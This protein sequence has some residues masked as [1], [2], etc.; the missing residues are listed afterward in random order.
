LAAEPTTLDGLHESAYSVFSLTQNVLETL[1]VPDQGGSVKPNLALS[2]APQGATS[3]EIKLRSGVK[4][5]DGT[6]MTADDVV[7]SVKYALE[8]GSTVQQVYLSQWKDARLIDSSTLRI[9][10]TVQDPIFPLELQFAAVAPA[11]AITKGKDF[12]S[13]SPTGTGP[14]KVAGWTKGLSLTLTAFD[15]YW[16][17]VQPIRDVFFVWRAESSVRADM[18]RTGEAQLAQ[19]LSPAHLQNV[20]KVASASSLDAYILILNVIGQTH[21]SI[22]TDQRVR[23][24]VNYAVDRNALR[25]KLFGG[26]ATL[27]K[28]NLV[29]PTVLGYND[30]LSD[31]AYDPEKAKGLVQDAGATGKTVTFV[32]SGGRFV[33]DSE[34][35]QLVSAQL[36]AIGLKVE[37]TNPPAAV[38][39]DTYRNGPNGLDRPD[40]LIGRAGNETH[41]LPSRTA[42]GFVRS[43][44][45]GGGGLTLDDPQLDQM[46]AAALVETDLN[47]R[48][49][50]SE[51]MS[52]YLRDRA[53]F[54]SLLTPN[55]TWG[56][57][58]NLNFTITPDGFLYLK[59]VRFAG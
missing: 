10:T 49:Q 26:Y 38:W 46:V 4:F 45:S 29:T 2:W 23:Q 36:V 51:D 59:T 57:T 34:V 41:D 7:A 15:D 14:Y 32:C 37:M 9:D 27:L 13:A 22:M 28:G 17:G 19:D 53:Y 43:R 20:P 18:V 48:R 42:T 39:L 56:V 30:S 55:R 52:K 24:A 16:G 40:I 12:M 6:T 8:K 44:K 1:A 35:C 3:W 33:N 47:K 5:H 58:K 21:G 11:S 50:L 25:D 54:V 31:Y